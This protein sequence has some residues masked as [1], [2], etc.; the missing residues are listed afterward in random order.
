[1]SHVFP[2]D[3][4]ASAQIERVKAARASFSPAVETVGFD[5]FWNIPANLQ[6]LE[7]T[8]PT[9]ILQLDP[10]NFSTQNFT[11]NQ[12]YKWLWNYIYG[13]TGA[14]RLQPL[15]AMRILAGLFSVGEQLDEVPEL[16]TALGDGVFVSC[17]VD[18]MALSNALTEFNLGWAQLGLTITVLSL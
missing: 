9:L 11:I 6:K 2:I 4:I 17:E 7:A 18:S 10:S 5:Q 8:I 12:P 1:M 14:N 3:I 15:Q 13:L 16:V